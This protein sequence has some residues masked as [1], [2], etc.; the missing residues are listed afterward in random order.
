MEFSLGCYDFIKDDLRRVVELLRTTRKT[1][2][3]FNTTLITLIQKIDNPTIF[4][5]F[6][7]ISPCNYIYKS[8]SK[9]ISRR[10]KRTPYQQISIERFGF[11]EGT[12]S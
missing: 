3:A 4:E 1:L 5:N 8:I 9:M 11:L 12:N 7:P 10:L 2:A 6:R